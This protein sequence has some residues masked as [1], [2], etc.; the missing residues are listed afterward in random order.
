M[1]FSEELQRCKRLMA[2]RP[3]HDVVRVRPK[4]RPCFSY[5]TAATPWVCYRA[6]RVLLD[7]ERSV[8]GEEGKSRLHARN[9]SAH[10]RKPLPGCLMRTLRGDPAKVIRRTVRGAF[11]GREKPQHAIS[12]KAL[13]WIKEALK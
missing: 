12:N 7:H 3:D 8:E 1:T 10:G 6:I 11:E 2:S 4:V 9:F 13:I 5:R